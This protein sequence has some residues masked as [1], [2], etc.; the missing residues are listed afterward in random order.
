MYCS[1]GMLYIRSRS[2]EMS[3]DDAAVSI[4]ILFSVYTKRW[5]SKSRS[6]S[7][8]CLHSI[9][10]SASR[11]PVRPWNN[12]EFTE[13]HWAS[14]KRSVEC[15]TI[16]EVLFCWPQGWNNV[17]SRGYMYVNACMRVCMFTQKTN[18]T[19][20]STD[21]KEFHLARAGDTL[22]QYWICLTAVR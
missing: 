5:N 12:V 14:E 21:T 17:K 13:Y 7:L 9:E 15:Y 8:L 19:G 10:N 16:A 2:A 1:F 22:R 20:L 4:G 18:I 3:R 6:W 11:L